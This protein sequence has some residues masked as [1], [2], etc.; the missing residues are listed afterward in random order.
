MR[1]RLDILLP[2]L[3]GSINSKNHWMWLD[4][5]ICEPFKWWM[6]DN[7]IPP[8][9]TL[10]PSRPQTVG[11]TKALEP[12]GS[13]LLH[14]IWQLAHSSI[15][16][17]AIIIIRGHQLLLALWLSLTEI[18]GQ[19]FQQEGQASRPAS[20][21]LDGVFFGEGQLG[22]LSCPDPVTRWIGLTRSSWL[23]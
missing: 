10:D 14:S 18:A 7:R 8:R 19:T 21:P 2:F 6:G 16:V 4:P 15:T 12:I 13:T 3:W 11:S 23:I 1:I 22:F 17:G 9:D 5:F 20:R